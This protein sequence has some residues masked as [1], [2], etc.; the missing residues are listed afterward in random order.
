MIHL[1]TR[2]WY[3]SFIPLSIF[4]SIGL[5]HLIKNKNL[6]TRGWFKKETYIRIKAISLTSIFIIFSFSNSISTIIYWDN[7]Y[8]VTDDEAQVIG[9]TTKNISWN[10]EILISINWWKLGSRL[11]TDLSLY[12]INYIEDEINSIQENDTAKLIYNL[13]LD[14]IY[15]FIVEKEFLDEYQELIAYFYNITVYEN[16]KWI[17]NRCDDF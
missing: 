6:K 1:F 4:T 3:Y 14:K 7:F 5:I 12:T 2:T 9:W 10:S 8:T 13:K 16:A 11:E 15:F 17:I